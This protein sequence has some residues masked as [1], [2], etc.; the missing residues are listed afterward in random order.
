MALLES[1]VPANPQHPASQN[2]GVDPR[3]L[4]D[5]PIVAVSQHRMLVAVRLDERRGTGARRGKPLRG[6]C[7]QQLA[8][9]VRLIGVPARILVAVQQFRGHRGNTSATRFEHDDR[10]VPAR[11]AGARTRRVPLEIRVAVASCPVE[12]QVSPQQTN[13][14]GTV[15]AKPAASSTVTASRAMVGSKS[16]AR[17]TKGLD[18]AAGDVETAGAPHWPF[19][20]TLPTRNEVEAAAATVES[21]FG[22]STS[23]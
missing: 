16:L 11:S 7:L 6:L 9:G 4:E 14:S 22:P 13:G 23:G 10:G 2:G 1:E 3:V 15:T 17:G 18:A 12:V 5:G 20:P 19:P 8:K 21:S